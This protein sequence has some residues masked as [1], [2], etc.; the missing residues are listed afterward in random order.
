MNGHYG[1]TIYNHGLPPNSEI[2]DCGNTSH[3]SG[4]T[5]ARSRHTGGVMTLLCDGSVRFVSDSVDLGIWR[6]LATRA[7]GEVVGE[8]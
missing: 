4:L 8:F 2:F 6:A 5:A 3:N 1:D 7:G